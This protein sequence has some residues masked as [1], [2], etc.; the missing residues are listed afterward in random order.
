MSGLAAGYQPLPG[1]PDEFIGADGRPRA[2][3]L[4]FLTALMKLGADGIGKRF[5]T[6][7]RHIRDTGVS[8][9]A[10][11]DTSERAWPLSHVPLLIEAGEWR[12]IARG[13]EQRARLLELVLSDI[14][15]EGRLIAAGDLPAAAVT[16]SPEFLHPLHGVKPQGG[17]FLHIYAADIGRGPDGRWWV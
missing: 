12:E 9:R 3:W 4:R 16:G 15:G 2:H 5:A 8:Y 17:K 14:Y 1:I 7:D 6:A 13:I 10:Y 11:G